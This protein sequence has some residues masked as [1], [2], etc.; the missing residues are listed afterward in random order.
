L[1]WLKRSRPDFLL[2]SLAHHLDDLRI[3]QTCRSLGIPYAILVQ[4]A[5]PYQW[6]EPSR[7]ECHRSAF[8]DALHCYFVSAENRAILESNLAL[9]LSGSEIVDNPFQVSASA[10]PTWPSS[11]NVWKLASVARLCFQAKAQDVLLRIMRQPKW[12][13][14]PLQVSLWGTDGGN[15]RQAEKLIALHHLEKQVK[16]R[17][18]ATDVEQ[19]WREHHALVLPSR[20]EGNSLAMIEAMLCRRVPIVTNVGRVAELVDDNECGFIAAAATV[21]LVDEAMER[22]WQ[23]RD[24]WRSMGERAAANIRQRHSLR[25]SEDFAEAILAAAGRRPRTRV[26]AAA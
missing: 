10:A 18:F 16:I 25:P 26:N 1:S 11:D 21:E 13:A 6:I 22:A 24:E 14:R 8:R 5:S 7:F 4:S 12:R 2:I 23:R 17:G 9:D 3:T 15:Q 19:L 20:F